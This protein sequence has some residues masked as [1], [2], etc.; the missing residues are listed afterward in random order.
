MFAVSLALEGVWAGR[1]VEVDGLGALV[2]GEIV[3]GEVLRVQR[4]EEGVGSG[5]QRPE[6]DIRK[7]HDEAFDGCCCRGWLMG[8]RKKKKG[9]ELVVGRL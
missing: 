3:C 9:G 8:G 2:D 4:D 5:G 7:Q 1:A 6:G